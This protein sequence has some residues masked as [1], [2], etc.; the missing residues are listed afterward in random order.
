MISGRWRKKDGERRE[1]KIFTIT[2][3]WES[4]ESHLI[5]TGNLEIFGLFKEFVMLLPR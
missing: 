5:Q 1:K 3:S 4:I 2:L